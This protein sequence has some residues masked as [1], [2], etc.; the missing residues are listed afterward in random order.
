MAVAQDSKAPSEKMNNWPEN[1]GAWKEGFYIWP[2]VSLVHLVECGVTI[3]GPSIGF[4]I[5]PPR[6]F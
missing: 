5:G 2:D 1:P 3:W 6:D 4:L